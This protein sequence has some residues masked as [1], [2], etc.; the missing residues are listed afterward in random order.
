MNL[1]RMLY[2]LFTLF[3][4]AFNVVGAAAEGSG[5]TPSIDPN[6]QTLASLWS[7]QS[8][9]NE[10]DTKVTTPRGVDETQYVQ[11]GGIDQ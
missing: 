4:G 11:I 6:V 2:L 7:S 8:M 3:I 9:F 10:P 1:H 5:S